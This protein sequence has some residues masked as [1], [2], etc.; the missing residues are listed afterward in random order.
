MK[1][2][3][4]LKKLKSYHSLFIYSILILIS[5]CSNT[6]NISDNPTPTNNKTAKLETLKFEKKP[7]NDK[8]GYFYSNGEI[9][10]YSA[11]NLSAVIKDNLTLL[12]GG[13]DWKFG[14]RNK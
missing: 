2:I 13:E 3:K 10:S 4:V 7:I 1:N 12:P 8:G 5:A 9:Y 11:N 14:R 6:S